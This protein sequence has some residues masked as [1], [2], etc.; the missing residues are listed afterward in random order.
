MATKDPYAVLGIEHSASDAEVKKAYRRLAR[1]NHPDVNPGDADA[2]KRFQEIAAAYEILKDPARRKRYDQTGDTGETP[3][4]DFAPG[5]GPFP[6]GARGGPAGGFRWS[7]DFSDLFSEIFSGGGRGGVRFDDE[8]DDVAAPL[9]ISFR[10]AV[11]G[12]TIAFRTRI[13]RRCSR[14]DGS[15]RVGRTVCPVCH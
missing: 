6:G 2:Q 9:T 11:M 12:G 4:P 10:D 13:P 3:E 7:G 5:A 14:C 8:D 15:G 1:K